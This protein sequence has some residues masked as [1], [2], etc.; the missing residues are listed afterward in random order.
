[1]I[2][3]PQSDT[4]MTGRKIIVDTLRRHGPAWR[5]RSSRER[6]QPRSTGP[7]VI[8]RATSPRTSWRRNWP[9]GAPWQLAYAIGVAQPV[10]V[11]V[12]CH[13]TEKVSNGQLEKLV[14]KHFEL[15][16]KGIL[17][18]L[19]C[20]GRIYTP[21]AAYGHFGRTEP[22]IFTWER[23]DKVKDLQKDA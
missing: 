8:W 9:N 5:G 20:A 13:G 11:M 19:I 18:T 14:R 2:G 16:P 6:I 15:T 23:T 17:D 12:F 7:R 1:V 3:G 21:T 4:G 22:P 10:S